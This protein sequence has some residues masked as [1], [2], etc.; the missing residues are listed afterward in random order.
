M[1]RGDSPRLRSVQPVIMCMCPHTL[2]VSLARKSLSRRPLHPDTHDPF[3]PTIATIPTIPNDPFG[4]G[5]GSSG[6]PGSGGSLGSAASSLV[7]AVNAV[8]AS[9]AAVLA[10]V[11]GCAADCH[12]TLLPTGGFATFG[13]NYA[14]GII[15]WG[16][17]GQGSAGLLTA[18]GMD[19][20][21]TGGAHSGGPKS[22]ADTTPPP[23]ETGL[24]T[25]GSQP[26]GVI[27]GASVSIGGQYGFTNAPSGG[28]FSGPFT[29]GVFDLPFGSLT[30]SIG[31]ASD[32][33]VIYAVSGGPSL[34]VGASV[35]IYRTTTGH[36]QL[37]NRSGCKDSRC[38]MAVGRDRDYRL[39]LAH[40]SPRDPGT[41]IQSSGIESRGEHD[42]RGDNR[43]RQE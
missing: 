20:I 12:T 29:T 23:G 21:W 13:V 8:A 28:N 15:R 31:H 27:A 11:F 37:V 32:G 18:N 19:L 1:S 5:S 10:R 33:G 35:S 34:G 26:R 41:S 22:G 30:A 40:G 14:A 36:A 6:G 42:H 39:L 43:D 16:S 17:G 25:G 9:A 3:V 2:C 7:S 24:S 4:G 38:S